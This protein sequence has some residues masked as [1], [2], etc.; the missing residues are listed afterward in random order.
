MLTTKPQFKYLLILKAEP[1]SAGNSY[2][3]NKYP[4]KTVEQNLQIHVLADAFEVKEN[5]SIVFFQIGRSAEVK[6]VEGAKPLKIQ[7]A[8]YAAHK[9]E[10]CLL[11][12]Q[13]SLS[14][15][16]FSSQSVFRTNVNS[17][18]TTS[19]APMQQPDTS[20]AERSSNPPWDMDESKGSVPGFQNAANL[21]YR[22]VKNDFVEKEI[23]RFLIDNEKFTL[24]GFNNHLML[25]N[26]N[27]P[28]K[29]SVSDN[30]IQWN[31]S[32]LIKRRAIPTQKFTN[33]ESRQILDLM[34]PAIL[35]RHWGSD[36]KMGTILEILR[37]RDDTKNVSLIDL[38][39]WLALNNYFK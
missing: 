31:I 15:T 12:N 39:V 20:G 24:N 9:W 19:V 13:D 38:A 33:N 36:Q 5:G 37:D 23:R 35:K 21:D 6:T 26:K 27:L 3:N 22:K 34:L 11:M 16:A 18:V 28:T 8:A 25:A 14:Y 10:N 30:D 32:Q 4:N 29:I 2:G 7:V 17:N 1:V